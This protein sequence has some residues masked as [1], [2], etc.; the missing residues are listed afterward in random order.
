MGISMVISFST[1]AVIVTPVSSLEIQAPH[2]LPFLLLPLPGVAVPG[3]VPAAS[4][5]SPSA[6]TGELP[7]APA[8]A[9]PPIGRLR[10][11]RRRRC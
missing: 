8:V 7:P 3:R 2:S 5:P 6:L 1:E 11:V 10:G 4:L 9:A